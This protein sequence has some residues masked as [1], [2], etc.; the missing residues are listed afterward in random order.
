MYAAKPGR[1]LHRPQIVC[2]AYQGLVT[3]R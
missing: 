2:V 1:P 3:E